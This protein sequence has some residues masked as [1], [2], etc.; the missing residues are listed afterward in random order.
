MAYFNICSLCGSTLDPGER[1]DC[2][3]ESEIKKMVIESMLQ[4]GD[5]GQMEFCIKSEKK[6]LQCNI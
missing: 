1:C 5:N 6:P 2:Q 3:Q 4:I